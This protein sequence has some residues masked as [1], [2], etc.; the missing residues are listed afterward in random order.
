MIK[1]RGGV[2]VLIGMLRRFRRDP[3]LQMLALGALSYLLLNGTS[4]M[5]K[6]S[7]I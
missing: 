2:E 6:V 7:H 1:N 4:V 3:E 5:R